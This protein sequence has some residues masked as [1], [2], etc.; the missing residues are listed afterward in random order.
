MILQCQRKMLTTI[1]TAQMDIIQF[2]SWRTMNW[3]KFH[4]KFVL[5]CSKIAH[6]N[7]HK[8]GQTIHCFVWTIFPA[9]FERTMHFTKFN[10]IVSIQWNSEKENKMRN[11]LL[12]VRFCIK[13]TRFH[14]FY[15][16]I[17]IQILLNNFHHFKLILNDRFYYIFFFSNH[18]KPV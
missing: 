10:W 3:T 11:R 6:S 9:S 12:P 13:I 8:T 4:G 7:L 15:S 18:F 16:F 2:Y 14:S 17:T 5:M 1:L